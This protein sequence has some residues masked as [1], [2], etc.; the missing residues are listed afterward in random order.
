M[1][2]VGVHKGNHRFM[3]KEDI[4]LGDI[5]INHKVAFC[6][7][8]VKIEK[9]VR[10]R[11][12]DGKEMVFDAEYLVPAPPEQALRYQGKVP[13]VITEKSEESTARKGKSPDEITAGLNRFISEMAA[14]HPESAE[15]FKG[16]WAEII[17]ILGEHQE[18]KKW[19]MRWRSEDHFCPVLKAPSHTSNEWVSCIY[20]LFGKNVR[21]EVRKSYIPADFD[22]LFPIRN[23]MKGSTNAFKMDW[24]TFNAGP[25]AEFLKLL[26]VL[27]TKWSNN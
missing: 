1:E 12:L 26:R 5:L 9:Y 21:I 16:L 10:L 24:A 2:K 20:L 3:K 14:E 23:R 13:A 8:V 22:A 11:D 27:Y 25:R 19:D 4:K 18:G 6:G 17:G 7:Y 15:Q